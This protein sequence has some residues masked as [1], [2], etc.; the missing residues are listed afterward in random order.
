MP[1]SRGLLFVD[2]AQLSAAL[3]PLVPDDGDRGFVVRCLVGEGPI[4][5]RGANYVLLALL[6]RVL[7][8]QGRT[9]GAAVGVP[10]P[11]R[12][13]PHLADRVQD[14]HYPLNLPTRALQELASGDA[15]QLHAMIDCLTD[16]PPQHALANV[17]MV[18]LLEALLPA[19]QVQ[20][21]QAAAPATAGHEPPA[22]A[23]PRA[24]G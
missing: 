9:P 13:P 1:A 14:G 15:E 21:A 10:V 12:L 23:P 18:A 16:G 17:A 4:H 7:Q 22:P 8:A 5:H 3:R 24:Q 6:A 20:P 11:M 2:E 19:A